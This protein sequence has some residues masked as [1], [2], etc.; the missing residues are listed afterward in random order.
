LDFIKFF[1]KYIG[2]AV[3]LVKK[4]FSGKKGTEEMMNIPDDYDTIINSPENISLEE[5]I[6]ARTYW[7]KVQA[8]EIKRT[9]QLSPNLL[10]EQLPVM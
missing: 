4:I 10:E 5:I 8:D 9:K 6:D 7:K 3:Q 2:G 1:I